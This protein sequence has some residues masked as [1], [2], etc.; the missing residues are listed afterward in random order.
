MPGKIKV[1]VLAGRN[2]PVMDRA[3]DTTDAFVEIKFGGV[4]HK[5]D[6]CRKSLNPHWNSTEWY[7]F[8]VDESELQDEPL[9]LRLMDHDTYSAN[10][11]IGKVVISLAPLLAREAN[12]AN[13]TTGPP[14]GAVMSGWIPVF[15]TMHGTRGELNIIVKVELFS[16]FNKYKTSSCGVQFFHCP[17]IPPGY[18]ATAIHGFVEELIVND[19]P[20]YQWIDKIR[21]PRASNEARQVAF[22]KLSN[23]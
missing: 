7:R 1:K 15:D 4:T 9:Q 10:D 16:D 22:I 6:V 13:G 8:E 23:Q 20:E 14:G 12:N 5:T 17:M 2:L 3:S 18:R 11:A 19:D 21:T